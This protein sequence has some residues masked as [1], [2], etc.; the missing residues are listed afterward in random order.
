[1]TPERV[2]GTPFQKGC[3]PGP[4]RPK[5][6]IAA[7]LCRRLFDK[8]AEEIFELLGT[9]LKRSFFSE[10]C[11]LRIASFISERLTMAYRS[12]TLRVRQPPIFI[13]IRVP[14]RAYRHSARSYGNRARACRLRE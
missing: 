11:S 5:N 14:L 1:M 3:A 12:N 4:G 9:A 8:E 10:S 2:F 6:D 13:M 7:L